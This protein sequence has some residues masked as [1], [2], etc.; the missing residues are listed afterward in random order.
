MLSYLPT[1]PRGLTRNYM[2]RLSI[3]SDIC[4]NNS[5]MKKKRMSKEY[6]INQT[7]MTAL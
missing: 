2:S 5:I 7:S 3:L 4:L 1:P 6:V